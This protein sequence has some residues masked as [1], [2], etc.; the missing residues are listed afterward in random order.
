MYSPDQWEIISEVSSVACI[1][2]VSLV[3]GRKV[4][5]IDGPILYIRTLLL[6]IY[7]ITWA[8]DLIACM[9]MSTNNGNSIS[10]VLGLFNCVFLYTAAKI[11]LYL[12]FIEKIYTMSIPKTS[13]L[14]SPLYVISIGLLVPF[15]ALMVLQIIYRVTLVG[16]EFP[17]H[18]SIGIQLPGSIPTMCYHILVISS[19][20]G[21]FIKFAFFP[22]TAQQT[23]HQA[24]SLH[25]LAKHNCI[26]AFVTLVLTTA[27]G[28]LMAITEGKMRGIVWLSISTL[29]ISIVA[30]VTHWVA[31]HPAE[32][33]F[34]EKSL[35]QNH[36]D[37]AIR[38]EIKQHQEVVI[39]TEFNTV[40]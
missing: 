32:L 21:V 7:G 5:S 29:D 34:Y 17:F 1:T 15:V 37:K 2:A 4:A 19:F 39:L 40:A 16:E 38:L 12:Y 9:L 8:F 26:A 3:F 11:V 23:T 22:S 33:Q 31:S 18:C 25:A 10:C 24:S 35:Q 13:R 27:N 28:L 30:C 6:T 20:L 14:R 36:G